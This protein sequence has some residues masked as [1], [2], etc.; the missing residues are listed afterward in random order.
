MQ[1]QQLRKSLSFHLH[2][3]IFKKIAAAA[4][5]SKKPV[6]LVNI[7]MYLQFLC[8]HGRGKKGW[9]REFCQGME[10]HPG[11]ILKVLLQLP[12]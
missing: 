1:E 10:M 4:L 9:G 8:T 11:P 2:Y 7:Y 3:R 6:A 12:T 5:P